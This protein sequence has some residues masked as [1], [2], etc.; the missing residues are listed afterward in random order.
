MDEPMPTEP[1]PTPPGRAPK[2]WL[3]G[4][5][6]HVATIPESPRVTVELNGHSVPAL[7]DSEP[8]WTIT[9]VRPGILPK[10][11]TIL[12]SCIHRDV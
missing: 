1:K 9:Q 3:A 5:I 6:Q 7:L 12:V 4:C 2:P 11:G 8:C 10:T